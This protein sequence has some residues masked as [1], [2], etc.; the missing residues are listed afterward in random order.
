MGL[1]LRVCLLAGSR[2]FA[3]FPG[4]SRDGRGTARAPS[5]AALELLVIAGRDGGGEGV[6]QGA[7]IDRRIQTRGLKALWGSKTPITLVTCGFGRAGR[8]S[9][10]CESPA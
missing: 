2:R 9:D 7:A 6:D 4:R 1:D 3:L 5:D 8:Q 10:R